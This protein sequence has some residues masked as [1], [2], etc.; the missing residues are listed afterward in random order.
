MIESATL[1][2]VSG[3][4]R[5]AFLR[6]RSGSLLAHAAGMAVRK[7]FTSFASLV[8]IAGCESS[9]GRA[10]H[11]AHERAGPT[12]A[13][14]PVPAPA[15]APAEEPHGDHHGRHG[16]IVMMDG[17]QQHFEILLGEQDGTHRVYFSS[18]ARRPLPAS[19]MDQVRLTVTHPDGTKDDLPMSRDASDA[20]WTATGKPLASPDTRIRIAY[21]GKTVPAYQF[22]LTLA[23]FK[24]SAMPAPATEPT[25]GKTAP[26][27]KDDHAGH[28]HAH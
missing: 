17:Y 3:E 24:A 5:E 6:G 10:S 15:P 20:Y 12:P 1:R 11:N 7:M 25:A 4:P 16:G 2:V 8:L 28:K 13:T 23:G 9:S 18:A 19:A 14:A 21:S 27:A 26:P 22:E